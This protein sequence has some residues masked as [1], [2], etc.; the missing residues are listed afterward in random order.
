MRRRQA[1]YT[2]V[3][4]A[5]FPDGREWV[6]EGTCEGEISEQPQ[7]SGGFGYD[8]VFFLP[9]LDKTMA[10]IPGPLKNRIS[11]RGKALQKLRVFLLPPTGNAVS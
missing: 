11:H 2:C 3:L 8:P 7:G 10:E 5:R 4:V 6:V 1:R 9:E